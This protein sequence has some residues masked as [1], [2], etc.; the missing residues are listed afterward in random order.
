M[1]FL[2]TL[3]RQSKVYMCVC[4]T[5]TKW[6]WVNN[7][8]FEQIFWDIFFQLSS[9]FKVFTLPVAVGGNI[10]ISTYVKL[11]FSRQMCFN[12]ATKMQLRVLAS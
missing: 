2:S 3:L 4:A 9:E 6:N 8:S 7:S 12:E 11:T 10:S 5:T 1:G